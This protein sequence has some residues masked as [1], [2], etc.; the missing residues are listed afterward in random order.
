MS[1]RRPT[2]GATQAGVAAVVLAMWL[3]A[4]VYFGAVVARAAFAVLPTRTLSGD[5]VSATLPAIFL[6]GMALAGLA[7]LLALPAPRREWHAG[8]FTWFLGALVAAALCAIS[9]FVVTPRIEMLRASLGISL[10]S[11]PLTDPTRSAF[12]HWH[13]LSVGALGAAMVLVLVAL[14]AATRHATAARVR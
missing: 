14:V 12:A 10:D 6:S 5:L 11:T 2:P 4:A 3:G 8:R 9:Q 13:L 7:A 1:P